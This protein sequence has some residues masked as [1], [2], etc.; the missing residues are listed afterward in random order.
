[1][2]RVPGAG[3]RVDL[4][5]DLPLVRRTAAGEPEVG[6]QHLDRLV[7][8][9]TVPVQETEMLVSIDVLLLFVVVDDI[10]EVFDR[11]QPIGLWL[12]QL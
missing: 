9:A 2:G 11:A 6:V 5:A 4:P 7:E 12:D 8:L 3:E 1:M 10:A